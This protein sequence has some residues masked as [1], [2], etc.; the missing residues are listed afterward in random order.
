MA[1]KNPLMIPPTII[2]GIINAQEASLKAT[3]SLRK[4]KFS[5]EI[6]K[7]LLVAMI[8]DATIKLI[9]S[10]IPGITPPRKRLATEMLPPTDNA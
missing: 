1:V 10:K 9:P 5:W 2:M 6:G 8:Q 7:S 4:L 3:I